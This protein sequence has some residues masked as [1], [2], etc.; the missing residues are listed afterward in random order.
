MDWPIP[1]IGSKRACVIDEFE[2]QRGLTASSL[3]GR[4]PW[5]LQVCL[6]R[7]AQRRLTTTGASSLSVPFL[8][9]VWHTCAGLSRL[10]YVCENNME[11]YDDKLFVRCE[12]VENFKARSLKFTMGDNYIEG[13]VL[14]ESMCLDCVSETTRLFQHATPALLTAMRLVLLEPLYSRLDAWLTGDVTGIVVSYFLLNYE[15]H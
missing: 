9:F 11:S 12:W 7:N 6:V 3:F 2:K 5:H 8:R 13:S 4:W 10:C 14:T 1:L 15:L